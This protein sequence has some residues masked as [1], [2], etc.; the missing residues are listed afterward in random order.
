MNECAYKSSAPEVVEYLQRILDNEWGK[1]IREK[2][3]EHG[4][5]TDFLTFGSTTFAGFAPP[6]DGTVPAGW[7][8]T[9]YVK[10]GASATCVVPDRRTKLGKAL[11]RWFEDHGKRPYIDRLPGM[12]PMVFNRT[13]EGMR[14]CTVTEAFPHEGAVYVRWEIPREAVEGD[15]GPDAEM[16]KPIP[17]SEYH[18]AREARAEM[19]AAT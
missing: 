5:T 7:R 16:W 11:S 2:G 14:L 4:L 9:S 15:K 12:V 8:S 10:G 3:A 6:E 19:L 17:M 13:D 18:L 1:A